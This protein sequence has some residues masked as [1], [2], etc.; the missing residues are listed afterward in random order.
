MP[1]LASVKECSTIDRSIVADGGIK[2]AGDIVKALAFGADFVMI[3]GMLAGTRPTPGKIAYTQ[4]GPV[5]EYRGMASKEAQED[6]IG[7]MPNWKTS[8]G[9]S[10]Y[11]EYRTDEDEVVAD[12]VGGLRSGLTYAGSGSIK[13]MQ[14]KARHVI[15]TQ[16]GKI[17]SMPHKLLR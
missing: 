11:V 12:I 16:S 7:V 15:I 13:E 6:F 3:G 1:T 10:T 4:T 2:T 9:V 14:S 5:K 8:E 17:E